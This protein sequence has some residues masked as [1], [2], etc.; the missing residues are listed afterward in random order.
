MRAHDNMASKYIRSDFLKIA[1]RIFQIGVIHS[2]NKCLLS[3]YFTPGFLLS[4]D[5]IT[6]NTSEFLVFMKSPSWMKKIMKN[7]YLICQLLINAQKEKIKT[8]EGKGT[9]SDGAR[10]CVV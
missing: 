1:E 4:A 9:G 10:V 6:M 8:N 7:M 5:E 3:I 2:L